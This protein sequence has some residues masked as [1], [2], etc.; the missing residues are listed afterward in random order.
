[1]GQGVL[2]LISTDDAEAEQHCGID[3]GYEEFRR[4]APAAASTS[5]LD[6]IPNAKVLFWLFQRP[7]RTVAVRDLYE[8]Y[9]CP[10][11]LEIELSTLDSRDN[12]KRKRSLAARLIYQTIKQCVI[13][14]WIMMKRYQPLD[15]R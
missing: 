4:D 7:Q 15:S 11:D 13:V 8:R 3:R 12:F 6:G 1:V 9:R 2:D 10:A 5:G 14:A